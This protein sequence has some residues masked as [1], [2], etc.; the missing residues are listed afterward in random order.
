[1]PFRIVI[2]GAPASGK[3]EFIERLKTEPEFDD[4]VFLEEIARRLLEEDPS[5]RGRWAEFH[6]EVYRRQ[7]A[8]EDALKGRS[9][10]TD[11]GTADAFAFH[12]E[13]AAHYGTTLE[14]EYRRYDAVILLGSTAAMGEPY[15]QQDNIRT[16]SPDE[17]MALEKATFN[18]WKGHRNFFEIKAETDPE[19]KYGHLRETLFEIIREPK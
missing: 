1:M 19:T 2:T 4:F 8:Q 11:R 10:I 6:H 3:S 9:F 12:P 13:T 5:Y 17:V 14:N 16:E 18:V 15:Y 7:L